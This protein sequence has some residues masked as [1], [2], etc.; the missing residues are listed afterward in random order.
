MADGE[1]LRAGTFGDLANLV[2]LGGEPV[3]EQRE[4]AVGVNELLGVVVVRMAISPMH[5]S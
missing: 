4:G 3:V 2:R 1:E 5:I